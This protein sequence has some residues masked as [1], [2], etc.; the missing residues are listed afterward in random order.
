MQC[1]DGIKKHS[2]YY[3]TW[4]LQTKLKKREY[5]RR[6]E[7]ILLLKIAC[8]PQKYPWICP[9]MYHINS[10]KPNF[11]LLKPIQWN[12]RPIVEDPI[13]QIPRGKL[14]HK[15]TTKPNPMRFV[16]PE[17]W[18]FL[19]LFL[20]PLASSLVDTPSLT[21]MVSLS[22]MHLLPLMLAIAILSVSPSASAPDQAISRKAID[23]FPTAYEV[24]KGLSFPVGILPQGVESYL[25]TPDGSFEVFLAGTCEFKVAGKYLLRYSD[26]PLSLFLSLFSL[27]KQLLT[28]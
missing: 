3:S 9:D 2:I 5:S 11:S 14:N 22:S 13:L 26:S 15:L 21:E 18:I 4:L 23:D 24:L 8:V 1:G 17:I 28:S 16:N 20:L 6:M 12:P 19:F 25:L 27:I 7:Y 10:S